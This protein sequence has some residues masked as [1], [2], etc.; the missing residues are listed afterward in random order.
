MLL[1][2]FLLYRKVKKQT[3]VYNGSKNKR[4]RLFFII[5]NYS[6]KWNWINQ[7]ERISQPRKQYLPIKEEKRKNRSKDFVKSDYRQVKNGIP[8]KR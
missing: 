3:Y 1:N 7:T 8:R 4:R 5:C 2:N 6:R